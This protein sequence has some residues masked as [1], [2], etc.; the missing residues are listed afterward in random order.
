MNRHDW[1]W[2]CPT[3]NFRELARDRV[4]EERSKRRQLTIFGVGC[5]DFAAATR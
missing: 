1:A 3:I 4:I 5:E 2:P